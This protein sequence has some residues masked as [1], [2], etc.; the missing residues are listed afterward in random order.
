MLTQL[1]QALSAQQER[2]RESA[3]KQQELRREFYLKHGW[4]P[5]N[6]APPGGFSLVIATTIATGGLILIAVILALAM[7]D[8]MEWVQAYE[9]F[10][11][12]RQ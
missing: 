9:Q 3:L 1:K 5:A 6:N 11:S 10:Q 8:P 7:S 2:W 4:P 12:L